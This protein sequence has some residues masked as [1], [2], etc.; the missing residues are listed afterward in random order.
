MPSVR[1]PGLYE[2]QTA[3]CRRVL[4]YTLRMTSADLTPS[5]AARALAAAR[6]G[7]RRLDGVIRE[8]RERANELGTV[9]MAELRSLVDEAGTTKEKS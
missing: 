5:D 3:R 8:L 7:S 9:Q 2:A 6:W 1:L 4:P